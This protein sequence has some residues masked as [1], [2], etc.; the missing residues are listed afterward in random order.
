VP[1]VEGIA[2]IMQTI[3]LYHQSKFIKKQTDALVKQ[4]N[5]LIKKENPKLEIKKNCLKEDG[6]Y[7]QI[8]NIGKETA[9]KI[10]L[11]IE[12]IPLQ[13][14]KERKLKIF[15]KVEWN[16]IIFENRYLLKNKHINYFDNEISLEP[17]TFRDFN[18][19][20]FGFNLIDIQN[21]ISY[22]LNFKQLYNQMINKKEVNALNINIKI[23]YKNILGGTIEKKEIENFS[24]EINEKHKNLSL[25]KIPKENGF[26]IEEEITPE[27]K[28]YRNWV[29]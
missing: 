8:K 28:K 20:E 3:I 11:E 15:K 5:Y 26:S 23:V 1:F 27:N 14:R 10:A 29:Y 7:L 18:K 2:I 9:K 4:T 17:H 19:K 22:S 24:V 16:K 13:I 21:T 25:E 6:Y 12:I